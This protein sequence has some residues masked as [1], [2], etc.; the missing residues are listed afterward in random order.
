MAGITSNGLNTDAAARKQRFKESEAA[1]RLQQLRK[2][3]ELE[4]ADCI[5]K[6]LIT[7]D[8]NRQTLSQKNVFMVGTCQEMCSEYERYRREE[9]R[10][11]DRLE[12]DPVSGDVDP[13]LTV[14]RFVRPAAG[15]EPQLP[16]DVRPPIVL[17]KTLDYLVDKFT[18]DQD[19]LR[20]THSFLRDRTRAIRNDFSIQ[21]IKNH[22]SIE[23]Y[24]RIS[25]L[26]IIAL[27]VL[28]GSL[29]FEAEMEV[30]ELKK[31][32]MSLIS[33]YDDLRG[34]YQS[35]NEPEFQAYNIAINLQHR[36]ILVK[37]N[38]LPRNIIL[39]PQVQHV[40]KLYG[41][42]QRTVR[43][44]E[45]NVV[46]VTEACMNSYTRF[47]K[48][49]RD[50]Q[51]SYMLSCILEEHFPDIRKGALVAMKK[52]FLKR[53]GPYPLVDLARILA[54]DS[55]EEAL[56]FCEHFDV[57]SEVTADQTVG[58]K[59]D[60]VDPWP[61]NKPAPPRTFSKCLVEV[62]RGGK[63]L[64]EL[65][66]QPSTSGKT[67]RQSSIMDTFLLQKKA[68][69]SPTPNFVSGS[70]KHFANRQR[71][72]LDKNYLSVS[73]ASQPAV[74]ASS[75]S[76]LKSNIP[77][78]MSSSFQSTPSFAPI[79][80]HVQSI[81]AFQPNLSTNK[82]AFSFRAPKPPSSLQIEVIPSPPPSV[83]ST[84]TQS[85]ALKQKRDIPVTPLP[86]QS[87]LS[88]QKAA[89][90]HALA[91]K[92][93][94]ELIDILSNQI[95][96]S[97][98]EECILETTATAIASI[99]YSNHLRRHVLHRFS[100]LAHQ[101][102]LAAVERKRIQLDRERKRRKFEEAVRDMG[103]ASLTNTRHNNLGIIAGDLSKILL[104]ANEQTTTLWK[105]IDL[106]KLFLGTVN[107]YFEIEKRMGTWKLLVTYLDE[108]H[109]I[110]VWLRSKVGFLEDSQEDCRLYKGDHGNF[111]VSVSESDTLFALE[112]VG[113]VVFSC[114]VDVGDWDIE[115]DR[116]HQVIKEVSNSS[117]FKFSVLVIQWMKNADYR[118]DISQSL[119][120]ASL[121]ASSQSSITN[122]HVLQIQTVQDTNL[123]PAL[124]KL[125][126]DISIDPS[127]WYARQ[128]TLERKR[129]RMMQ[130]PVLVEKKPRRT[131]VY[132]LP[133]PPPPAP[134]ERQA[135]KDVIPRGLRR[136]L[137]KVEE[138][139]GGV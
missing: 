96:E 50:H 22:V 112:N 38:T 46:E 65:I 8:S 52:C 87:L 93:K 4:R 43:K 36:D 15:I 98:V 133:A 74:F 107:A 18:V 34:E 105:P 108:E 72:S 49:V 97:F 42:A 99:F 35:P 111:E 80:S 121:F 1:V 94:R 26:H 85:P 109:P 103:V 21:N 118:I 54:F 89:E 48:L 81:P 27:H 51:T 40:L 128:L 91:E 59:L 76:S 137:D 119:D 127:P 24:E 25:R 126:N 106:Q 83:G 113:A 28:H 60:K 122:L 104:E 61:H 78:P 84:P 75:F 6:G 95:I 114:S 12:R 70:T 86:F 53:Y 31:T 139:G 39:S 120:F 41:F 117:R 16:S 57:N 2:A 116:F 64:R 7:D 102:K 55:P 14:K 58:V 100:T 5:R 123:T 82:Q 20:N 13:K 56:V 62:K 19:T 67:P 68:N 33:F 134:L 37:I 29:N 11:I 47:F 129:K 77:T 132:S 115:K 30:K 69:S 66:N 32:L 9:D 90:A 101:A 45:K 110:A 23:C 135:V 79:F 44:P 124:E 10:F 63:Q 17:R 71:S 130:S 125:V 138:I 131:N 88:A 92:Q 73:T 136:L 3:R